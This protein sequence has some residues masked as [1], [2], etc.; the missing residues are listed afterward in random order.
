VTLEPWK[1]VQEIAYPDHVKRFVYQQMEDSLAGSFP[2]VMKPVLP[3][4][5]VMGSSS[6]HQTGDLDGYEMLTGAPLYVLTCHFSDIAPNA[7]VRGA[8]RHI[9]APTLFCLAGKGWEWND[10]ETYSFET[11]DLLIVPPYTIHQH[12]G[13]K[14]IG[15]Q[16]YVPQARMMDVLGL[17]KREQ[18]KFGEKPTFPEGTEPMYD[19]LNKLVGYRIK[20]GVLGITKDIEVYLGAE[21]NVE[22][23]FQARRAKTSWDEPVENTYDRYLKL[24]SDEVAFCNTVTHV[25]RYEEQPWEWTRQG[26][27]KWFTHPDI[28]SS[29]RRVWL[30]MQEIPA[31]SRSGRHRHMA[32]EQVYVIQG[33]GCDIHDGERWNW[34]KGDLIN[35]PPM[36][37]HQHFNTDAKNPV[38]L[39]SSVP[40]LG[41]DLG[42]GGIEQLEDAPEFISGASLQG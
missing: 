6:P 38:L 26:R 23:A 41:A 42:L 10:G 13:D 16:I 7:P 18:I 30:Y 37:E 20:K 4:K 5:T 28:A 40:G 17:L 22:A 31:G 36:A 29:A 2:H 15:C 19:E 1:G 11:Y 3:I 14:E 39:Y 32:E 34:E 12:G 21:P 25:I 33:Q 35:I 27:L 24:L 8:H 9:S